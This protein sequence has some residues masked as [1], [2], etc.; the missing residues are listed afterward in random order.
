MFLLKESLVDDEHYLEAEKLAG[1][2]AG[3]RADH[4]LTSNKDPDLEAGG[5]E[6]LNDI[7]IPPWD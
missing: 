6:F 1:V 5:I 7:G 3:H 4:K 2:A